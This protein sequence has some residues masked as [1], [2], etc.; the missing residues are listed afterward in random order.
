MRPKP[1]L[2]SPEFKTLVESVLRSPRKG[3][4]FTLSADKI[5]LFLEKYFGSEIERG[6]DE[7]D[8]AQHLIKILRRKNV[9]KRPNSPEGITLFGAL[10]YEEMIG[11]RVRTTFVLKLLTSLAFSLVEEVETS[12]AGKGELEAKMRMAFTSPELINK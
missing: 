2:V 11:I 1:K 5:R 4:T 7:S 8:A 9:A 3:S 12:R 10:I 6:A